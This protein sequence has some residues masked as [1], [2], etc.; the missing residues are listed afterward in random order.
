MPLNESLIFLFTF[1]FMLINFFSSLSYRHSLQ[2]R[3]AVV[4]VCQSVNTCMK[5]AKACANF[6]ETEYFPHDGF[7]YN[8]LN[9]QVTRALFCEQ[10]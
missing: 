2:E 6:K 7:I 8:A 1:C 5:W 4:N 3:L 9:I 10:K